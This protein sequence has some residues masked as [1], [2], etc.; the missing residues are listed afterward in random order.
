MKV[1]E[2][3]EFLSMASQSAMLAYV[4]ALGEKEPLFSCLITE[5]TRTSLTEID[6]LFQQLS[7]C[8]LVQQL[9]KN[10]KSHDRSHDIHQVI[11]S[12]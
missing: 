11:I 7:G 2:I 12:R 9:C 8:E 6:P 1:S 4:R 3:G 10:I 5:A